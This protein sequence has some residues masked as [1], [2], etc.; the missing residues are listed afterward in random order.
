[1]KKLT[2]EEMI[3]M[4]VIELPADKFLVP[5]EEAV[6]FAKT[7]LNKDEI[8]P[9]EL[10]SFTFSLTFNMAKDIINPSENMFALK[11]DDDKIYI[12][13]VYN[14]DTI[15]ADEY[16][17]NEEDNQL[18]W[19]S[20]CEASLQDNDIFQLDWSYSDSFIEHLNETDNDFIHQINT[21]LKINV[22]VSLD[23]YAKN[24]YNS[25]K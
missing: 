14:K 13:L 7:N 11:I 24:T 16:F 20:R 22:L 12:H 8:T 5:M 9:D 25:N 2:V 10:I 18:E 17:Y 3:N 19:Y 15:I 21:T 6:Q 23:C 1:M 4:K